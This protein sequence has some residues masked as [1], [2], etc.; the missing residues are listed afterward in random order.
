MR[1]ENWNN[2]F[3]DRLM[4]IAA[5]GY[6]FAWVPP[7]S[8]PL[9][10]RLDISG[11]SDEAP[12]LHCISFASTMVE[13]VTGKDY[14]AELGGELDYSSPA[15]AMRALKKLGFDSTDQL[16]GSIFPEKRI[17][18]AIRGDLVLVKTDDPS[19]DAEEVRGFALAVGVADPPFIWTIHPE[20]G[21]SKVH[22]SEAVK[23][24]EVN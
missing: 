17:S 15:T 24:F 7:S 8:Q 5:D 13:A 18:Y 16:L 22:F 23:A 14:Y 20:H 1:V 12:K 9:E 11:Q 6:T 19:L 2:K 21:L 3:V 4:Q 10:G